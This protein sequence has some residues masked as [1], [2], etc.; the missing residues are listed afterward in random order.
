MNLS[1]VFIP[2]KKLPFRYIGNRVVMVHYKENRLI[3]LN[4]TASEIWMRLDGRTVGELVRDLLPIFDVDETQ[5]AEDT[6]KLLTVLEERD[7]LCRV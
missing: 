2:P 7:L 3:T 4:E 5:L 6:W 1:T